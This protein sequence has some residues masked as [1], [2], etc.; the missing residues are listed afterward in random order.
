MIYNMY[1]IEEDT[2][3]INI[4]ISTRSGI[5]ALVPET[6]LANVGS[7]YSTAFHQNILE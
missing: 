1:A 3:K 2:N 7:I 4:N 5:S 6:Y